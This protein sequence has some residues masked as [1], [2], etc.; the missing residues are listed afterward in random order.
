MPTS[1]QHRLPEGHRWPRRWIKKALASTVLTMAVTIGSGV[2]LAET[3]LHPPSTSVPTPTD[4]PRSMPPLLDTAYPGTIG[5]RVDATDVAHGVIQVRET[6]PTQG[7]NQLTLLYPEW[8]PGNHGPSGPLNALGGLTIE[9]DGRQVHWRR[10][11]WN[12]YVFH[13][14]IPSGAPS[15]E[16][17][18]SY[19]ADRD[20]NKGGDPI[21][22]TIVSLYWNRLILYPAGHFTRDIDYQPSVVFPDG[23]RSASALAPGL[24]GNRVDYARVNLETLV[25]SPVLAGRYMRSDVLAPGVS[26]DI[27]ADQ[28]NQLVATPEQIDAHKAL[29]VQADR[30]FGGARHFDHYDF[31]LSLSRTVD[32]DGLEHQ[33]SSQIAVGPNYFIKWNDRT[34]SRE[35]MPHEFAHGWN[36][37]YRRPADLW[38]PNF[39]E[40]QGGSLLWVYEGQTQLWGELL[41]ERSGLADKAY[42]LDLLASK[43]AQY[44]EADFESWR[45]I[46]DTTSDPSFGRGQPRPWPD[47]QGWGDYYNAAELTWVE[48]DQ[49]IRSRTN[50]GS[51]LDDFA[52]T[53]FGVRNGDLGV[54][55]YTY[56]DVV[57]ALNS[58]LPYDW[59]TFLKTRLYAA[60]PPHDLAW[61]KAAGYALV[62]EDKPGPFWEQDEALSSSTNL[63]YSV[64]L[65]IDQDGAVSQVRWGGPAFAAGLGP[66]ARI[67]A[68]DGLPYSPDAL[69]LAVANAKGGSQAI[70][71]IVNQDNTVRPVALQWNGGLRYPRLE[72]LG[73]AEGGLDQ[74]LTPRK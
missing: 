25:D 39:N 14:D 74:M 73:T 9:A 64:G 51:S 54:S 68:V 36:G 23:W 10:D 4:H 69:K 33:R 41:Q 24:S 30:L 22:S 56:E 15:V 37:K 8:I 34:P 26:L 58:V 16:V 29:V 38:A 1:F 65:T 3:P 17:R 71:L 42:T 70:T 53:F 50:G 59:N 52:R 5:L 18:Y 46:E 45:S 13:L 31:L 6:I 11:E 72:K 7:A 43:I 48:A 57:A 67:V 2:A 12:P 40:P 28:P 61:L 49:L 32:G 20:L 44:Q 62:F 55:T 60:Q 47:R 21:S 35:V 19:F 27:A 66:G 63:V